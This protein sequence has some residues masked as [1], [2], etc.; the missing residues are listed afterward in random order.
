MVY[1]LVSSCSTGDIVSPL[2]KF[3]K[4]KILGLIIVHNLNI[5]LA[6]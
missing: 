1:P 4:D 3:I 5:L 2:Y 6:V